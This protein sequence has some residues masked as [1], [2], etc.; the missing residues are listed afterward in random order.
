MEGYAWSYRRKETNLISNKQELEQEGLN[1]P[2]HVQ[3]LNC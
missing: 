2:I 3:K 1:L